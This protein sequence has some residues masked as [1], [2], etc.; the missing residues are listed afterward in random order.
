MV[1]VAEK[2]WY[3]IRAVTGQEVKIKE[4]IISFVIQNLYENLYHVF[5][6]LQ[7][8]EYTIACH[9]F[10]FDVQFAVTGRDVLALSIVYYSLCSPIHIHVS[11]FHMWC[12]CNMSV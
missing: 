2:K 6:C 4:Y 8:S 3:V 12:M 5:F 9:Y 10:L 1:E 7:N 11:Y